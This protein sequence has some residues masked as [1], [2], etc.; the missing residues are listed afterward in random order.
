MGPALGAYDPLSEHSFVMKQARAEVAERGG[1]IPAFFIEILQEVK[2]QRDPVIE[3]VKEWLSID[4]TD[5]RQLK[6][7]AVMQMVE[8]KIMNRFLRNLRAGRRILLRS[9]LGVLGHNASL[10]R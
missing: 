6:P 8:A 3:Q 9:P 4:Q 10:H 5:R 2:A 7:A 1:E